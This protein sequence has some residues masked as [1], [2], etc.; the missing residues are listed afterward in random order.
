MAARFTPV[1]VMPAGDRLVRAPFTAAVEWGAAV[2]VS[3][4]D[5]GTG[6]GCVA[7][8]RRDEEWGGTVGR[9]RLHCQLK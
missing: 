3:L 8:L 6:W 9:P 2:V 7:E 4:V 1:T 5:V